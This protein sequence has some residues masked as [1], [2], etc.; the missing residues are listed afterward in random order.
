MSEKRT[1][2]V[3]DWVWDIEEFEEWLPKPFKR[4]EDAEGV[5][6][7]PIRREKGIYPTPVPG[8]EILRM[9]EKRNGVV[10]EYVVYA[11]DVIQ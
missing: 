11:A 10:P 3:A 9:V 7:G 5:K 1:F 4:A 8:P 2:Y 6:L